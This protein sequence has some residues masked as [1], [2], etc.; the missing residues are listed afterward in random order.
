MS[1]LVARKRHKLSDTLTAIRKEEVSSV[2]TS[3]AGHNWLATLHKSACREMKRL[4]CLV[5]AAEIK[6]INSFHVA[7]D[8]CTSLHTICATTITLASGKF[9]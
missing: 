2:D 6:S 3:P 7:V 4:N 1:R 8:N 5:L 9:E